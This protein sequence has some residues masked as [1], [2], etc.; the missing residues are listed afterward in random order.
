MNPTI[1]II[2][3]TGRM[4]QWLQ[5]FF[6]KK[7]L[8]VLIA[9][10]KTSLSP[11][12]LAKKADIVIISVP[13]SKTGGIIE[14]IAPVM[15]KGALLTDIASLK[16]IPME[17][18][19]TVNC[20]TLGMHPLFGP[21]AKLLQGNQIV[22]TRQKDNAYVPFLKRLFEKEGASVIEM[23]ADEHD[24]QMAYIQALTHA[25]NLLFGKA[26]FATKREL[27][28]NLYTPLFSLQ[29]LTSGRVYQQDMDLIADIELYNPY[30]RPLLTEFLKEGESL[31]KALEKQDK[32]EFLSLFSEEAGLAKNF[33]H[34]SL[35]QTNKLLDLAK[36]MPK[37]PPQKL[38]RIRVAKGAKIAY[39]GPEGTYSHQVA[40]MLFPKNKKISKDLLYDLFTEV[41]KGK[42]NL[43]IVPAENSIEGTIRETLDYLI[44]FPLEV[45]G[46][47]EIP[48]HHQLLSKE[49]RLS[50]IK[51]VVSHS[52]ALA[53]CKLWLSKDLP[54]AKRIAVASTTAELSQA[55]R[56]V[57][58]VAS[59]LAAEKYKLPIL[60]ADIGDNHNNVTKFYVLA[61]HNVKVK[62]LSQKKTLLL[63]TVYDRVGILRDIL[64]VFVN[65]NLN[66]SKLES[67]PSRTKPWDY[68]FFVEVETPIAAPALKKAIE[69]LVYLCPTIRILGA[70]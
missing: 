15:R 65:H 12:A 23:S 33:A 32:S 54:K 7:K 39:L 30:F 64:T 6:E 26:V 11:K 19:R 4:G 66:L 27:T 41:V 37:I 36:E 50:D 2:G 8:P 20:G 63:L 38:K 35:F 62:N 69:E 43:A 21:S 60:V 51:T 52:Q 46:S 44:D 34:F 45:I 28:A 59:K 1:G 49:K 68:H 55:K 25:V 47:L 31:M 53:Q 14:D 16:V 67:R 70:T 9:G 40:T 10:R 48:I 24:Y 56:G 58:F 13:I 17:A 3:G 29:V 61:K 18:M 5:S 42:A 22:F 57:A